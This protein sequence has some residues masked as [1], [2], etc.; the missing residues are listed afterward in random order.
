MR[1]SKSRNVCGYV[2]RVQAQ[3][4]DASKLEA[5][6]QAYEESVRP[7]KRRMEARQVEIHACFAK[8]TGAQIAEARRLTTKAPARCVCGA[9]VPGART[10]DHLHGAHRCAHVSA[11]P[12]AS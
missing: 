11:L 2:S 10:G 3:L 7:L 4:K 1:V 6:R 9:T 8:L 12:G 5:K